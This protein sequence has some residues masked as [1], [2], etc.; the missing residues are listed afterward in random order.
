MTREGIPADRGINGLAIGRRRAVVTGDYLTDDRFDHIAEADEFVR[1]M[2]LHAAVAAPLF[3]DDGLLGVIK[4]L[5]TR[6]DAYDDEDAALMEAFA[7][8]AV[9]AIQNARLIEELG[10]SRE[11]ISRRAD[12][13]RTVR[14]IAANISAIRD[15]DAVLQQT[16]DEAR[17]LLESDAARIDLVEGEEM[18]WAYASGEL[19]TGPGTRVATCSSGS[20]TAWP[21]SLSSAAR[22]YKT[23]DYLNDDRSSPTSTRRR[24]G[25]PDRLSLRP[26]GADA[27]RAR[28]ARGDL[29]QQQLAPG[30]YDDAQADLLQ[31]LADQA[32]ITIQNARLIAEL[33]RSRTELRRRAEEEQSLREIAARISAT[34]GARDVLQR[35]VDE[36]ARLLAADEARI[37]LI[38]PESGLLHGPTTRRRRRPTARGTG[39]TTP[40]RRSSRASPAWR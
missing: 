23:D 7:D 25:R 17:R 29:R 3:T 39:P 9:V 12:A 11:E 40:T 31:A 4:V 34:K 15:P 8:Q 22:P 14:E 21:G 27:R 20:V 26:G 10:Q 6:R 38:E 37:D 19:S 16:V 1:G 36:A 30:A 5:A 2:G 28:P 18:H 24:A 13:E 35:T 32:A 33:N